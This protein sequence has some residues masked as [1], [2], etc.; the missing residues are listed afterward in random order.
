MELRTRGTGKNNQTNED[1]RVWYWETRRQ[2]QRSTCQTHTKKSNKHNTNI[3][4]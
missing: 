1:K 4:T 3:E 2:E